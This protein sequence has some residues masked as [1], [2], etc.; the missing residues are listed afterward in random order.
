MLTVQRALG[1]LARL[2]S[3]DVAIRPIERARVPP[4]AG[5]LRLTSESERS[6][7]DEVERRI[8]VPVKARKKP[9]QTLPLQE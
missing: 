2:M 4:P 8:L 7:E 3:T 5:Q 6:R 1:T 9:N